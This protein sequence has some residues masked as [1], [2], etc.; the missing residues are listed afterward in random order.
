MTE[1]QGL[2]V[3]SGDDVRLCVFVGGAVVSTF[4]LASSNI[5]RPV[6]LMAISEWLREEASALASMAPPPLPRQVTIL[7]EGGK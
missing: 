3:V 2:E 4:V 7:Q 1:D 6:C 5:H